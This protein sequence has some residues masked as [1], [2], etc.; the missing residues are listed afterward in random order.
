MTA[1]S[2]YEGIADV[3]CRWLEVDPDFET[4]VETEQILTSGGLE[5]NDRFGSWLTFGTA[6]I[7]GQRGAGPMRMNR[8][9]V[10]S[11]SAAVAERVSNSVD[12]RK[13]LIVVGF[14]ARYQSETFAIDTARVLAA[15]DVKC[16]V[17]SRPL[18][19]PV[20][21]YAVRELNADA[22]VMIT[23]SH[24]PAVDSGYKLY[25]S[26]GAQIIPPIDSDILSLIN[27]NDLLSDADLAQSD[28]PLISYVSDEIVD[29]YLN[30]ASSVV[31]ARETPSTRSI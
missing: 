25:W 10:R 15:R 31:S 11:V 30:M 4:R 23:A 7:R 17:L 26:D 2:T 21:A 19:I 14:D 1:T 13:P 8:V 12:H 20:L 6:G 18:P 22:G 3:A 16:I 28:N 27:S 5:L 24:N 29:R 9:L